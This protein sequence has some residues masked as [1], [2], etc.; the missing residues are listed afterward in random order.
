MNKTQL[1]KYISKKIKAINNNVDIL[2][3]GD[4]TST[5]EYTKLINEHK[6]LITLFNKLSN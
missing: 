6:R 2:I 4:K 3:V 1:I 5:T